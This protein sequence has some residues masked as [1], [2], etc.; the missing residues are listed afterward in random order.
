LPN[1]TFLQ[2]RDIVGLQASKDRTE[3]TG[4][5]VRPTADTDPEAAEEVLRADLVV[6]ATGRGSRTPLWLED[7]GYPPVEETS[8]KIGLGY[9]TQHYRFK[10]DPLDG[11]LAII[12]V[13]SPALPRGAIFTKT[14]GGNFELSAYGMLGDHPPTDQAGFFQFVKSLAVPDIYQAV[15]KA[16]A[17]DKPVAFRFPIT[18][19]RHYERMRRFPDGLLVTGDA[20]CSFNPVYAQGMTVAALGAL[21][22]R[23]HLRSGA[24]PHPQQYF[25]DLARNVIDAPWDMTNTVDLSFPGVEGNRTPKVLAAQLYLSLVQAAATRDGQVTGAYMRAAGMVD[26]PEAL[27][28]PVMVARVLTGVARSLI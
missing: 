15:T 1:V 23:Q 11:D 2:G 10:G 21:T 5:R 27:M 16:K 12:P 9:V 22:M 28:K 19:R 6:D 4:V 17:L 18:T 20:V 3:V 14:D 25:A 26:R 13:A 7:L 24:A 8:K